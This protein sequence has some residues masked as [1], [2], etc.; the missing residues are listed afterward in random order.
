MSCR[1]VA[2]IESPDGQTYEQGY[3]EFED[4]LDLLE[5]LGTDYLI[6]DIY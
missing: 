6:C 5:V 2:L 1:Y 3:N 4:L